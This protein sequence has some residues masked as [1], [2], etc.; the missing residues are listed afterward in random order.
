MSLEIALKQKRF[1]DVFL[2]SDIYFASK[3]SMNFQ[4]INQIKEEF[5]LQSSKIP[6]IKKE[7]R[8]M[9]KHIHP[10]KNAGNFA[11]ESDKETFLKIAE[12]QL[13]F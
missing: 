3:T 4:N 7:L 8:E 5:S 10:D 12:M 6:E 1:L 13:S 11:S 2:L 9:Q